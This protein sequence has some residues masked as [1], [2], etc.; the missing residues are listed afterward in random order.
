MT[1]E[2]FVMG[3]QQ[4]NMGVED[5]RFV[6]VGAAGDTLRA[7]LL[8]MV[9]NLEPIVGQW[10]EWDFTLGVGARAW[11]LV[12]EWVLGDLVCGGQTI[13]SEQVAASGPFYMSGQ[14]LGDD[15]HRWGSWAKA[16]GDT[17]DE[18]FSATAD[19]LEPIIGESDVWDFSLDVGE[20]A[21][22]NLWAPDS[23]GDA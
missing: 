19:A 4:M 15:G 9:R 20:P 21:Y 8:Q 3:A 17:L 10:D 18:C 11:A 16:R 12:N 7:C 5:E 23:G 14:P 13:T 1:T 6:V 2:R 22:P